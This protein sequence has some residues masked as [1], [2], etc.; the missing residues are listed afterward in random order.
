MNFNYVNPSVPQVGQLTSVLYDLQ[1]GQYIMADSAYAD[2]KY[3]GPPIFEKSNLNL[4]NPNSLAA[5]SQ[6]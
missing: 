2:P 4:F 3:G 5:Q 6:F 1:T